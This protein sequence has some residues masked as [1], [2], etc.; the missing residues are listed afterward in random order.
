MRRRAASLLAAALL[1]LA[2]PVRASVADD[3]DAIERVHG[4]DPEVLIGKIAG[5]EL[6]ARKAGG[7]DLRVFLAAWGYAH[8]M[9]GSRAVAD[10][11]ASELEA[12]GVKWQ[13]DATLASAYTLRANM[14]EASGRPRAALAWAE[15]AE[16]LALHAK[17][18]SLRYWVASSAAIVSYE[19]GAI[20]DAVK[21]FQI[22][23]S[24]AEESKDLRRQAQTHLSLVSLLLM[25]KDAKGAM[26]N[27]ETAFRIAEA[28]G[29]QSLMAI[30]KAYEALA[31]EVLGD[32]ERQ[33]RATEASQRLSKQVGGEATQL[34]VL[35]NMSDLNLRIGNFAAAR[36]QAERA[37]ALARKREDES[38]T[39]LA[40][41]NLG[42]ALI[43]QGRLAEGRRLAELGLAYYLRV[44]AQSDLLSMYNQYG[45]SLERAGDAAHALQAVRKGQALEDQLLRADRQRTVVEMQ[46][47][48]EADKR[49]KEIEL[50][51]R[52]NA[53]KTAELGRQALARRS[54]W[55]LA[56]VLALA[57]VVAIL[58]YGRVRRANRQLAAKNADLEYLSTHDPLTGLFNRRHFT[59][60]LETL[61][62]ELPHRRADDA[63]DLVRAVFLLD[64][65]HFKQINDRFGHRDG[66]RA[67]VEIARRLRETLRDSE[68]VVRWGG[69]E[70]LVLA[71]A[72]RRAH[73]DELAMRLLATVVTAPVACH[74]GPL[75]V[76]ASVGFSPLE[77][78]GDPH[79]P[80]WDR[81]LH[82]ADQALFLAKRRGRN[83]A[84]GVRDEASARALEAGDDEGVPAS[85][86]APAAPA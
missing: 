48:F 61:P 16:P 10:A 17:D 27:A 69:E 39:A 83:Q 31:A 58:L 40:E 21:L 4:A 76:T 3:V 44:E 72:I 36:G 8:A 33:R 1:L 68:T 60:M 51:N 79:A 57:S 38:S 19:T 42:L 77:L 26:S 34:T 80:D 62:P 13:D 82:R 52:D 41:F 43:G 6:A 9:T 29:Q 11:A 75:R 35:I 74:S 78:P 37:L 70:F 15:R 28:D 25:L 59:G 32:H 30:A 20:E 46:E 66:D 23:L 7:R 67:L 55:L 49:S 84:V 2:G 56:T 24:A 65:D 22:G 71:P 12:L 85:V 45:E 50:L 64:I 73:L 14:L 54:S 81:A 63:D 47:R 5:M 18:P 86:F 53:L